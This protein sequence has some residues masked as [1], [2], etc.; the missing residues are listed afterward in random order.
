M[1]FGELNFVPPG[2]GC[3]QKMAHKYI[4]FTVSGRKQKILKK[5]PFSDSS[6][7]QTRKRNFD[8]TPNT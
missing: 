3:L 2:V 5:N 8:R 7:Y 1:P 4:P 6:I